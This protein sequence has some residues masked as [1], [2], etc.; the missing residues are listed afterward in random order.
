M[1][2]CIEIISFWCKRIRDTWN[3]W[4]W[5]LCLLIVWVCSNWVH[6]SSWIGTCWSSRWGDCGS[7]LLGR[8]S[9]SRCRSC[10]L[11]CWSRYC[12]R[13]CRLLNLLWRSLS[14]CRCSLWLWLC[15]TL[16][17]HM[18]NNKP[19]SLSY[20]LLPSQLLFKFPLLLLHFLFLLLF[21]SFSLLKL[22]SLF[23][24]YELLFSRSLIMLLFFLRLFWLWSLLK[25]TECNQIK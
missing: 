13:S 8:L 17:S 9:R 16:L 6:H 2:W 23:F 25:C 5:G 11:Y 15:L 19:I 7:G 4:S 18:S 20:L 22:F 12:C 10:L 1:N 24:N 21:L 14:R 3:R